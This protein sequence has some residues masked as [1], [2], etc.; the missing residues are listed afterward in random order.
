MKFILPIFL[1]LLLLQPNSAQDFDPFSLP[2]AKKAPAKTESQVTLRSEVSPIVAG[3]P[4]TV[5]LTI[6][7]PEGWHSYYVNTG[8]IGEVFTPVWTLPDGFTA[9]YQ[10]WPTPHLS[11]SFGYN[12]IGYEG[13]VSHLFTITPSQD[14][15]PGD[16][17]ALT[18]EARWQICND[19]GCISEKYAGVLNLSVAEASEPTADSIQLFEKARSH[20]PSAPG[21]TEVAA[22]ER[23]NL[24]T[25][26]ITNAS[27]LQADKLQF[28]DEDGQVDVQQAQTAVKEGDTIILQVSRNLGNDLT[29]AGPVQDQLKGILTDGSTSLLI[30]TPLL[31][32]SLEVAAAP[33]AGETTTAT[34]SPEAI[35]EMAKLY[36]PTTKINFE[37]LGKQ[38]ETTLWT[39]L[40]GAFVGGI[41]LNLMPCVF[42]VLGLKVMGFV[43]QAGNDAKKI[44]LHGLAFTAGLVAAM[45]VLA[46]II[47]FLKLSLGREVNWGQQ[48]GNS[49]F[50]GAIII[51][52]FVLGLNMAGVFEMGTSLTSAGQKVKKKGYTGSFFSGILTTLIATPCSGPFLGAAMSYTLSQP[53]FIALFLFTIFALGI[54][55][56]YLLL[57][58]FPALIN[59]LPRPGAWM[60]TFKVTMSFA[61]FATVAFFMKTFGN[62]TGVDGLALL[63]MGLVVLGLALYFFGRWTL[64]HLKAN[65]RLWQG[66]VLPSVIAGGGLYL[67]V[68]AMKLDP[69][70]VALAHGWESWH[71][72]KVEHSRAKKRIVWVDYTADW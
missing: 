18:L 56:P 5:A 38:V 68:S 45:W 15:A 58:F 29:G 71:P 52:L 17:V 43:E 14:L 46:G 36:D 66:K 55:L 10:G 32:V 47:L 30:R 69:P 53:A 28:F 11:T 35:A 31:G 13:T 51:L 44:R 57:S 7:H 25:L 49:Y 16:E 40:F 70:Q 64:P 2:S 3:E 62:Q 61:L 19:A 65:K 60:E 50:V 42:P 9:D 48:M 41:L 72:G 8:L 26:T 37:T 12:T 33:A 63:L 59:K 39:A 1:L 22:S 20:Y 21:N 54:A 67:A 34:D 4:F 27:E 23:D 24:I 6:E